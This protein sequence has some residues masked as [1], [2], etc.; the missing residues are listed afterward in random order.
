MDPTVSIA[1][2][3]GF[4][5]LLV[6]PFWRIY[7]RAGLSPW[8]SLLVFLPYIGLPA[9]AAILAF[10]KWPNGESRRAGKGVFPSQE[11]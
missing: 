9:A 8:F 6:Y 2:T 3:F 5:L 1:I 10:Q 4:S 7:R 11:S